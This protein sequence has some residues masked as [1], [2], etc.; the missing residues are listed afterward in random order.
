MNHNLK[1][2]RQV[3][4]DKFFFFDNDSDSSFDFE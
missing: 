4:I 3:H 1:C 2:E